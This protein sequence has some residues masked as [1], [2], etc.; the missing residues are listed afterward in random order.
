MIYLPVRLGLIGG[1]TVTPL[2][3]ALTYDAA[4]PYAVG[5]TI[6]HPE[7][8]TVTWE[9]ARDLLID[10]IAYPA[11]VGCGDVRV[12]QCRTGIHVL[13]SSCEGE[14]ELH[15]DGEDVQVFLRSSL[16]LVPFGCEMDG[17]DTDRELAEILGEAA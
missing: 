15:I 17:I 12:R 10:A 8:D 11:G 3:A 16:T 9:F 7:G 6:T 14:A 2:T 5:M 1:A 4:D 13:L